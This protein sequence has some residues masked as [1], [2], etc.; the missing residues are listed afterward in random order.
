M[1][2]NLQISGQT[3]TASGR[4]MV[5]EDK[6]VAAS[7]LK[8][9]KFAYSPSE[10]ATSPPEI[11]NAAAF[12]CFLFYLCYKFQNFAL[13]NFVRKLHSI[14]LV[15]ESQCFTNEYCC[16]SVPPASDS[17]ESG[18]DSLR[19][20]WRARGSSQTLPLLVLSSECFC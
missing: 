19:G 6:G 2:K 10:T 14:L 8:C 15:M 16:F 13:Q 7:A 11:S 12:T 17:C 1:L 18:A 4:E 3:A 5:R 9:S 20:V